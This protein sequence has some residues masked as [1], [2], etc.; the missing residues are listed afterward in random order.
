MPQSG[1]APPNTIDFDSDAMVV[2]P[3]AA[4]GC[5]GAFLTAGRNQEGQPYVLCNLTMGSAVQLTGAPVPTHG[6]L[7][8]ATCI[9]S[10]SDARALARELDR[11]ANEAEDE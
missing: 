7:R 2:V 11:L 3:D 5:T 10:P 8:A 1:A 4:Y 6:E 9:L